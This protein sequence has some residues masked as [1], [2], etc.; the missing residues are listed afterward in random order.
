MERGNAKTQR[1]RG[2]NFD[3]TSLMV[4]SPKLSQRLRVFGF[5]NAL[6][7]VLIHSTPNPAVD[8][9]SWW[10]A[11]LLGRDGLCRIAVPYFFLAGGFFL[12][13]HVCEEG[14]WRRE[15]NKRVRSLVVPYFLWVGIGLVIHFG[16]YLGILKV[17][18][19]SGFP[20]PF[21][22]PLSLWFVDN[23]GINPFTNK[24]GI[25]W[26]V[27]DLFAFVVISPFL[28]FMLKRF[29]RL[30]VGLIFAL[31]GAITIL[32]VGMDKGWYNFFEY[33]I[34]VR[35]LCYFTV[36]L[37]MRYVG[38]RYAMKMRKSFAYLF[39]G[40]GGLIIKIVLFRYSFA[41]IAVAID[42]IMVPILMVGLFHVLRNVKLPICIVENVF[43]VYL[44]HQTF[45][46][47][48]IVAVTALGLRNSLDMSIVIWLARFTFAVFMT[49]AIACCLRRYLPRV[50]SFIF[51]GR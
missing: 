28:V 31:Y 23:L 39:M 2:L 48:S 25:L 42:V 51:G 24:I 16:L 17:G 30:F 21:Y 41:R 44:T 6:L 20:N 32:Q 11:E 1:R 4:V 34:S 15:V 5:V 43:A 26:F 47:F 37:W 49:M 27:R 12:A 45:L 8:T 22:H 35:G 50:A 10:V 46:L 14:W 29:S 19:E 36:G 13:G 9:W 7:I 18:K 3:V 38:G 33:F 40:G